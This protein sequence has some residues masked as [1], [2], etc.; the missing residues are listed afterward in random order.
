MHYRSGPASS[1][2]RNSAQTL[3]QLLRENAEG[4]GDK[5]A[6]SFIR[7][8]DGPEI[9]LTYRA[10]HER[11]MA[12]G[13]ELQSLISPGERALLLYP[14][15]LEFISA[16]FGCLYAGVV[17]V[18]VALPTRNRATS[19][20]GSILAASK[21]TV[22]LSTAEQRN[23]SQESHSETSELLQRPWIATDLI[24]NDRQL[25]W[26]D[27]HIEESHA[28][29]LQYTSGSTS[30]PK[31]V[32]LSHRNLLFNAS[33]ISHAFGATAEDRAVF[34]LPHY[35][36]MGLIGGILQP[37][38]SNCTCTLMAPAAFLQR[39]SIWLETISRKRA[40]ISGGPN[41]GYDLCYRRI[42]AEEREQLDLSCWRLAFAGAE[43]VRAET[44]NRFIE[45]FSC[46]GFRRESFFPCYGLAEAT[47]M[48]SGGPRDTAPSIV[49]VRGD[50]L[51][52]N[53]VAD[54]GPDDSA[55]RTLVGCGEN[56]P[57]QEIVIADPET[58]LQCEDQKLG[59]IWLRGPSV[60]VG[61]YDCPEAT[62]AAFDGYL[63]SGDGPFLRTG[64]LGFLRGG[65][66]FVTA[67][68]KDVI[69]IRGRNH[70]PEDLE[71]SVEGAHPAFRIGFTAAFSVDVEDR[72]QLVVVQEIEPR[73]RDLDVDAALRAI[74]RVIAS[75]HELEVHTVVLAKAGT[76]SKTSSNKTQR[77]ACRERYLRG[78]LVTIASWQA[79]DAVADADTLLTVAE[80]TPKLVGAEAIEDWLI[81]RIATRLGLPV[82]QVHVTTPFLEF[83]LGSMDAVELAADLEH[84]LGRRV[85]PTAVYNHPNI[86]ALAQWLANSSDK[87]ET[88]PDGSP[89]GSNGVLQPDALL[90]EVRNMTDAEIQAFL[91]QELA[92]Q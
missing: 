27:L 34:W 91:D 57:G 8:D 31:G 87:G 48:A 51:E 20:I 35:H 32:V 25:S 4:A 40:T 13:G 18:P 47:L 23:K 16:F 55:V 33:L 45:T 58:L 76:I 75:I 24:S 19:A 71:H 29:F 83:G 62:K 12:I 28:A 15:G 59:E 60:A 82:E 72:E 1:S 39:P 21:P 3:V 50:A 36:D 67:R 80:V 41:F 68:L 69:V 49:R 5:Q 54:A 17:A 38:Y 65:Q 44:I 66:L 84:Q 86:A 85:A 9:S 6:F 64:D 73:H 11:A 78:D 88:G 2:S 77:S 52:Q 46:C 30:S 79:R 7:T 61:Y 37:I 14:P 10:L 63:K 53:V 42:R 89:A 22:I 56:L 74:R 26:R 43:R 81:Q 92:K 70:Y 90:D